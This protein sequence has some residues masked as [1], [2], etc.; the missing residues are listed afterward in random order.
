MPGA[1]PSIQRHAVLQ[2]PL[3]AL[4]PNPFSPQNTP[5]RARPSPGAAQLADAL[6]PRAAVR[7][8]ERRVPPAPLRHAPR[9]GQRRAVGPLVDGAVQAGQPPGLPHV[10]RGAQIGVP[11]SL[12]A[13]WHGARGAR[14]AQQAGT[15]LRSAGL[16]RR[17]AAPPRPRLQAGDPWSLAP[18]RRYWLRFALLGSVEVPLYAW[19]RGRRAWA[20]RAAASIGAYWAAVALLARRNW[21]ATLYTLVVPYALSSLLLMFGNWWGGRARARG[22]ARPMERASERLA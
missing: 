8:A 3:L 20:L 7:P 19:R 4:K 22:A 5:L 12:E 21:V 2:P 10:G 14:K 15:R 18:P 6:R 11:R 1:E 9:G 17:P 16:E 13:A